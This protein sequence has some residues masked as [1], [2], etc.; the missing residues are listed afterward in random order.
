MFAESAH[1]MS[2]PPGGKPLVG[3][4]P[5]VGGLIAPIPISQRSGSRVDGLYISFLPSILKLFPMLILTQIPT[6]ACWG[7]WGSLH[8]DTMPPSSVPNP[9]ES[10]P[11]IG[12]QA[13]KDFIR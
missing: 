1:S 12:Y 5:T 3:G 4:L 10:F 7:T 11:P 2:V 9:K 6:Y 13:G 8:A